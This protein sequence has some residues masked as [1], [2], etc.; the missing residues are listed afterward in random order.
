MVA[1]GASGGRQDWGCRQ[2]TWQVWQQV[3]KSQPEETRFQGQ[4]QSPEGTEARSRKP[5]RDT[6]PRNGAQSRG[7]VTE[8]NAGAQVQKTGSKAERDQL[9]SGLFTTGETQKQRECPKEGIPS[10]TVKQRHGN[11]AGDEKKKKKKKKKT[12]CV[13][14]HVNMEIFPQ[15]CILFN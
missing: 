14:A 4:D 6:V 2:P 5:S 10:T 8:N 12:R 3:T 7:P 13:Q 1:L 15:T 9:R 11:N